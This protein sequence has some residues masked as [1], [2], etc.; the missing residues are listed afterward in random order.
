MRLFALLGALTI[1]LT[2]CDHRPVVQNS[3]SPIA[4]AIE[5]ELTGRNKIPLHKSQSAM[6]R[7]LE[8][9]YSARG[10]RP[11]WNDAPA[12]AALMSTGF[13]SL[14][15]E[16]LRPEDYIADDA[17]ASMRRA[18]GPG[19]SAR[20]QAAFDLQVSRNYLRALAHVAYGKVNPE[21]VGTLWDAAPTAL[22]QRLTL[23]WAGL[24]AQ[25]GAIDG[26][27]AQARPQTA[28]YAQLRKALPQQAGNAQR[29]AQLRVN[30]ERTRWLMQDLPPSYVLVDIADYQL[31]YRRPD[32]TMWQT[33]VVVG[34]PYRKTPTF[35]S[36]IDKVTVN[37]TWTVPPTIFEQDIAPKAR[38]DAAGTLAK[39]HLRAIDGQGREVPL[40][41][42]DWGNPKS[43]ILRQDPGPENALGQVKISFDNPYQVYLHDTPSK[44]LFDEDE[45]ANSSGC[46]RVENALQLAQMIVDDSQTSTEALQQQASDGKTHEIKLKQTIPVLLHYSTIKVTQAGEVQF[47][48]DIYDRDPAL[49]EA[50]DKS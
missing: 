49:L 42:I 22:D 25:T 7:S 10:F 26:A 23:S 50:L 29:T 28:L 20:D 1:V 13:G 45:R 27:I 16:G 6:D 21:S 32:G 46:I 33:K 9:M 2:G 48:D 44:A 15:T 30:L 19:T 35:R 12:F 39:K 34:K 8:Q 14:S 31:R 5:K 43:V 38:R 47:Q 24:A 37:P 11:L 36:E 18:F 3:S 17:Y 41:S 40:S 4:Q